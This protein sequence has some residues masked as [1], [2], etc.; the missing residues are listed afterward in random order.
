MVFFRAEYYATL[1]YYTGQN[2][3]ETA[4]DYCVMTFAKDFQKV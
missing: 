3:C 4:S 1:F 2:S